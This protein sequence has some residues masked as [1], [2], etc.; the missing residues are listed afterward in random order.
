M[1]MVDQGVHTVVFSPVAVVVLGYST[2]DEQRNEH[3]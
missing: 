1:Q 3:A 2:V